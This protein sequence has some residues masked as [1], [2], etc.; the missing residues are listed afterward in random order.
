MDLARPGY[1]FPAK[2]WG[3]RKN[4][5]AL[6]PGLSSTR[7]THPGAILRKVWDPDQR[8]RDMRKVQIKSA[9]VSNDAIVGGF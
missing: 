6:V 9:R 8:R 4:G 3:M 7:P 2:V 5:L 1:A